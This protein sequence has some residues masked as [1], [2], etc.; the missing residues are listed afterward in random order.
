MTST[1]ASHIPLTTAVLGGEAEVQ[2]L[3]G[4]TLRLK[5]PATTQNGQMFRLKGH[6]MPTSNR[7]ESGDLY[8]TVEV[9]LPKTLTPEERAHY[10]ALAELDNREVVMNINKYTEKAQRSRRRSHRSRASTA[11]IR[12]SNPSICS[13]RSSSSARGSSPVVCES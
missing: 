12:K 2:T 9:Q 7:P 13:R 3:A 6:G 4:K 5:V 10:E 8:A 1:R 11:A